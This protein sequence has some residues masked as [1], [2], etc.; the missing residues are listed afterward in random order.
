MKN[1]PVLYRPVANIRD[2]Q[3]VD[4]L[5]A[6]GIFPGKNYGETGVFVPVE[7]I[8][9]KT[10]VTRNMGKEHCY[11]CPVGCSQ[12][13]LAKTG[14]YS[15][16]MSEGPEFETMYSFGGTTGVDNI[17]AIIAADRMSD[18]LG[19]DTISAGATIA[20]AMELYE[21]GIITSKDTGGIELK[22]GNHKAMVD[23][24]R[25]MAYREGFGDLLS[26]GSKRAA[27]RIGK[28][29]G[30]YAM[31]VKG[32][33]LPGYD[34]R[35]AK[36]HGLNYATAYT[37][38]DHNRGYAFQEIFGIPIPEPVDR[39]SIKGKGALTKWNQDVRSAT[40]DAPTMC[41][42]LLDMAVPG[43]ATQNTA[44]LLEAVTGLT[45]TPDEIEKVGERMNN[46]ARLFNANEG[47]G[48]KDDNLPE[49]ILTEPIKDG[50]S[51][52]NFIS[53]MNSIRCWTSI[54]QQGDGTWKE[55]LQ[56]K[57][58]KN[59]V[60]RRQLARIIINDWRTPLRQKA[61]AGQEAQGSWHKEK[62]HNTKPIT[63]SFGFQ[64][65]NLKFEI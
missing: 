60:S 34:I 52:G 26:D 35:G 5:S 32:L 10:Q 58:S 29:S 4:A 24:L 27:E 57:N 64:I 54:M 12:L 37:G 17:D 56:G 28:G 30:K 7:E 65:S 48:R 25:L 45:F 21:K 19:I 43:V 31:H 61:T 15:G 9:V 33:E 18:E 40:C 8:G 38:A 50:N 41:A 6:L 36:A 39:F 23:M 16:I 1:S 55:C 2:I 49:R 46:L 44:N 42:F 20:F 53:G 59:W 47:F 63:P 22:F 51:K 62:Y 13:K 3:E 11:G 14:E